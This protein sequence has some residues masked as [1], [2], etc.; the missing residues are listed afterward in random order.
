MC[1]H[2]HAGHIVRT[3][4]P[5]FVPGLASFATKMIDRAQDWLQY[6]DPGYLQSEALLVRCR[7]YI[8]WKLHARILV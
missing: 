8:H 3:D 5:E 7:A 2:E 6:G 4:V 1:G